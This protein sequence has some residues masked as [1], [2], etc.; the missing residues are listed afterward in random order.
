MVLEDASRCL[1]SYSRE[2]W[3]KLLGTVEYAHATSVNASTKLTPL[4]ID[5]GRKVFNLIAHEFRGSKVWDPQPNSEFASNFS[6][7]RQDLV[8]KAR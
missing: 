2:N 8:R 3:A 4:E 7:Y 1:V 6:K 5:S